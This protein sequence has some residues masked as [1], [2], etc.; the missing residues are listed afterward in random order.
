M[1]VN[2]DLD[3]HLFR[4]PEGE[5]VLLESAQ[6]IEPAGVGLVETLLHDELGP[7]GRSVQSLLVQARS[8]P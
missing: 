2:A 6:R 1:Y 8:G 5:W 3:I 7:V 4:L